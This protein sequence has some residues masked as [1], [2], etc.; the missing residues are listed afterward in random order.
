MIHNIFGVFHITFD[1]YRSTAFAVIDFQLL[2][3]R[4]QLTN[5]TR[6]HIS[7]EF[8]VHHTLIFKH[9][10]FQMEFRESIRCIYCRPYNRL[11]IIRAT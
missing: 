10:R 5:F 3:T 4:I 8:S 7:N 2:I 1:R 9:L 6:H 11:Q